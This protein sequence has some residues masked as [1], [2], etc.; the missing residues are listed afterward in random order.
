M[1]EVRAKFL[2]I[3]RAVTHLPQPIQISRTVVILTA[4]PV[5]TRAVLRHLLGYSTENVSGTN[6]FR[7]QFEGLDVAVAEVGPGNVGAAAIATRAC[8]R[9]KPALALFVGVAGGVKDVAIGDIVAATKVYG[10]ESGKDRGAA[11]W[12]F[13]RW[14]ASGFSSRPTLFASAHELEQKARAMCQIETWRERLSSNIDHKSARL[15]VGPIAAGE[16]VVASKRAST[17]K[18]IKQ[19]YGDALA[20]EMEGYGFLEGVHVS[21]PVQGCVI[22]G[23]SDLLS[24]KA[25]ADSAGSQERAADAAAAVA[26]Q[27]LT[28]PVTS[29]QASLQISDLKKVGAALLDAGKPPSIV[30]LFPDASSAARA[31][32]DSAFAAERTIVESSGGKSTGRP[33]N[34]LLS[35][36]ERKH[37]VVGPPGSGKTHALWDTARQMLNVGDIIPLFLPA[38]QLNQWDELAAMIETAAPDLALSDI[39]NDPRV[40]V[41]IDG[42]SEFALRENAVEKQKTL[43]ALGNARVIVNGRAAAIDDTAFKSRSLELLSPE[44]VM[45]TI[46]KARPGAPIPTD[47]VVELLRLPLLLAIYA[48]SDSTASGAGDLLRQF[49][50]HLA[51]N[52]PEDFTLIL[53]ESVAAVSLSGDHAFGRL[54]AELRTRATAKGIS[55]PTE[56]LRRL[57]TIIERNGQALPFHDLYW[58]WLCGCGLLSSHSVIEAVDR[59]ETRESYELALQS[60]ALPKEADVESAANDDLVL[61]AKLDT[62]LGRSAITPDLAAGIERALNDSRLAVRSR[63]GLAALESKKS[64][65]LK[66][67]LDTLSNLASARLYVHAWPEALDL[68]VL[69][70]ERAIVADWLGSRPNG[71]EF[72]LTAIAERGGPE[73]TPWLEQLA[74]DDR[75]AKV[76]AL[77][78][79][80]ACADEIPTWGLPYLDDLFATK[81]W[82]LR[83]AASRRSNMT[84]GRYVA[85]EYERLVSKIIKSN[86][87]AWIEL[88]RVLVSCAD[89]PAFDLLVRRFASMDYRPQEYLGYAVVQ[90]G[91]PW[92][93]EFQRRAFATPKQQPNPHHKLS[94]ATSTQIDDETA[95]RWII[96]GYYE[97]GWRVLIARHGEAI[98]PELVS[99]LPDSFSNEHYIPPLAVMR[100]LDRAPASLESEIWKR[101][102]GVMQP[103]AMDHALNALARIYPTGVASIVQYIAQ[104][105][106]DL[107]AYHV[108]Q[109]FRL[110]ET[111]RDKLGLQ[112]IIG[113]SPENSAPFPQWIAR[114][115]ATNRWEDHFTPQMLASLPDL[116]VEIVLSQLKHDI[117]KSTAVLG[118]LRKATTYR[119]DLLDY[120][121]SASELT[122]LI[123]SVFADAFNTFP[124]LQLLRCLDSSDIDQGALLFRLGST[125]NPLHRSAHAELIKRVLSA[126]VNLHDFRSVAAMLRGHTTDEVVSLL[127]T[128]PANGGDSWLWLVREIEEARRERLINEDGR[129]RH[130]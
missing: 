108:A 81:P 118:A 62:G 54:A 125:S 46:A 16:K 83:A 90:R 48:L 34:S 13:W 32:L 120:M 82:G 124:V 71:S 70:R 88:N 33:I 45:A 119:Q 49:H 97:E 51:R 117:P 111:W 38:G 3:L 76:D 87:S 27:M 17:A 28:G 65:H 9:Y 109:V 36:D 69:F 122:K 113:T 50:D 126:S 21:Y 24:G 11:G 110:Y 15:F 10:Y 84:L 19:H 105:P 57:G 23:I 80:L 85:T 55:E 29:E 121:F 43:R 101:V 30:M 6:F 86:S 78:A 72:I 130:H 64:T 2:I 14:W 20:V 94:E 79:A 73:W 103:M 60:G 59:L 91:E 106:S 67:A 98:L 68:G 116:A 58:S 42:W 100:F 8:E 96:N 37:L 123:P 56:L 4:L 18:L 5:E 63:G 115:C 47:S 75:I 52:L 66:S 129:L 25:A 74:S 1:L 114:Y 39:L 41:M 107:P 44:Q 12:Q 92:V 89:D 128:A 93:A 77:S 22:R 104:R 95:R 61:A 99:K 7:A 102:N 31:A 53:A 112:L 26:F 40:C 35:V 127:Q